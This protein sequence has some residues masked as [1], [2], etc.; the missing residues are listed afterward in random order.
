[1]RKRRDDMKTTINIDDKL[2]K[3]SI[4]NKIKDLEDQIKTLKLENRELK[5][6]KMIQFPP[7][8]CNKKCPKQTASGY[9]IHQQSY[10]SIPPGTK[11]DIFINEDSNNPNSDCTLERVVTTGGYGKLCLIVDP[12]T[13]EKLRKG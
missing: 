6:H 2:V 1:M 3:K 5:A 11:L 13:V 12:L 7:I 10:I 8:Q 4:I 9:Y